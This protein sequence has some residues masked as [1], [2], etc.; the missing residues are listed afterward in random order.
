VWVK[1]SG[2]SAAFDAWS[3]TGNFQINPPGP[4]QITSL[5]SSVTLPAPVGTPITLSATA[6][7]GSPPVQFKFWL[8]DPSGTW[9]VLQDYS[10]AS[11]VIWTPA[12]AGNYVVQV[13]AR[14]TGS[15]AAFEDWRGTPTFTINPPVVLM[16]S[17]LR[18]SVILPAMVTNSMT[19]TAIAAG[20]GRF[21]ISL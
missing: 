10:P 4:V 19:W 1:S 17:S 5:A 9:V 12:Q 8:R 14:S 16:V 11:N 15:A 21:S 3:S 7:G 6:T 2:S 18:P 13:W 20:S